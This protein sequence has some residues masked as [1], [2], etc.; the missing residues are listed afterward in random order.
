MTVNPLNREELQPLVSQQEASRPL[1]QRRGVVL[2]AANVCRET[3]VLATLPM[4]LRDCNFFI[5]L[6]DI[7]LD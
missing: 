7:A 4:A 2:C 5:P 6:Q 3:G 1:S